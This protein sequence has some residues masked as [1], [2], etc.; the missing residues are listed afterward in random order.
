[1]TVST[2]ERTDH[3]SQ[4]YLVCQTKSHNAYHAVSLHKSQNLH[5]PRTASA[6]PELLRCYRSMHTYYS[7]VYALGLLSCNN[8]DE[9]QLDWLGCCPVRSQSAIVL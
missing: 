4:N 5:K 3:R 2:A 1:M 7:I 9:L 6:T 8:R